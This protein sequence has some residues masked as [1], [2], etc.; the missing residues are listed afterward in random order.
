MNYLSQPQ[1]SSSRPWVLSPCFNKITFLHQKRH[2]ELFLG[3]QLWTPRT[4][5]HSKTSSITIV[6]VPGCTRI[7]PWFLHHPGSPNFVKLTQTHLPRHTTQPPLW[8]GTLLSVL[9]IPPEG[10]HCPALL[11]CWLCPRMA[12]GWD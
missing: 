5:Y 2:Q 1:G 7:L 6:N 9:Q 4:S 11:L 3:R 10:C 12:E 8:R